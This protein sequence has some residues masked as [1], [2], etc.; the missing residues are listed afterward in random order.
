[1]DDRVIGSLVAAIPQPAAIEHA[2]SA[3]LIALP[4]RR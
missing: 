3:T 1:V 4:A 2:S